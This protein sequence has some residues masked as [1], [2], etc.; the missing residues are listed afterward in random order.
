MQDHSQRGKRHHRHRHEQHHHCNHHHFRR[1]VEWWSTFQHSPGRKYQSTLLLRS[2]TENVIII[3]LYVNGVNGGDD[4]GLTTQVVKPTTTKRIAG[5]GLPLPKVA[6]IDINLFFS[7]SLTNC[8][9][10]SNIS[11]IHPGADKTGG[12]PCVFWHPGLWERSSAIVVIGQ[13]GNQNHNTLFSVSRPSFPEHKGLA[14]RPFASCIVYSLYL[15]LCRMPS[16]TCQLLLMI[17][18]ILSLPIVN[19]ISLNLIQQSDLTNSKIF[20]SQNFSNAV[21]RR[22][23][24]WDWTQTPINGHQHWEG[25]HQSGRCELENHCENQSLHTDTCIGPVDMSIHVS[26]CNFLVKFC[27]QYGGILLDKPHGRTCWCENLRE[28]GNFPCGGNKK[29]WR[30]LW[31]V[32]ART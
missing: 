5:Y 14:A 26:A 11:F 24:P 28:R 32:I 23:L 30:L 29:D 10:S 31:G 17:N 7:E 2:N 12:H 4:D 9:R 18:H 6:A 19:Q 13:P 8:L 25:D 27:E 1:C 16:S 3:L 20:L 15:V 21:N 22:I